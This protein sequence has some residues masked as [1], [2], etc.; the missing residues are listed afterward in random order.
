MERL[1]DASRAARMAG[2]SRTEIQQL[3]ADGRL[4][5]FEGKVSIDELATIYPELDTSR[6]YMSE[7]V[8]QIKEDAVGKRHR[9]RMA[10]ADLD[11]DALR[12]E[13]GKARREVAYYRER[14]ERYRDVLRSLK[15]RLVALQ[16]HSDQKSRIEA[17]IQWISQKTQEAW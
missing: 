10:D 1:I 15:E 5:T 8:D 12:Q 11:P 9:D 6:S 16:E 4:Q 14:A 7:V 13:L 2:V 17:L 3:I